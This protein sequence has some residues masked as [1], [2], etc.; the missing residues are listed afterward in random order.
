MA[1]TDEDGVPRSERLAILRREPG[2][3][4]STPRLSLFDAKGAVASELSPTRLRWFHVALGL[5]FLLCAMLASLLVGPA[6]LSPGSVLTQ[7][8]SRGVPFLGVHS[9]LPASDVAVI[10][11]LRLPRLVL[12]ALVGAMLAL[13]GASY[14]GVFHNPLADP[15]LLGVASGAGLGATIAVVELPQLGSW[16][17]DPLPL[18]AFAGAI[19]AVVATFALGRSGRGTRNASSLILAG[20]AVGAFFTAAQTFLQQRNTPVLREV[21]SWILGGLS[22][23]GWSDVELILPYVALASLLLIACRGLLDALSVGDDEANSLGVRADRVRLVVVVA[24]T[25]GTAA[26]V[27]VSGL[28]GFVGIIV[29]HTIRLLV[30]PSYRR[31]LPLSVLFGAGLLVFADVIARTVLSP[32]E[33]PLGVVTAFLGAP[34]FLVVLRQSRRFS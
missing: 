21:Y 32:G 30:G 19:V 6:N 9:S 27:A 17:I 18:A 1:A 10:W 16:T 3:R 7:I 29:P 20:V 13:A 24:A 26:A 25:L 2:A 4:L 22:T 33:I 14:Q 12:G 15:Y 34:F 28:I 11:Q 23:A 8:V 5:V 31:I